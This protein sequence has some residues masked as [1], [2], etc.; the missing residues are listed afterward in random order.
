M[1]RG[2]ASAE[3]TQARLD[4]S[5]FAPGAPLGRTRLAVSRAGFG[6]Y[7]VSAGVNEHA[8]ALE[9]ALASGITLVDTSANY[10]DGGSEELVGRVIAHLVDSGKLRREA[11]V[12]VSKAGYL[13]GQNH[14]LSQERKRRGNPFPELVLYGE[15]LE[16]C[17]H[18]EFLQDQLTRSLERLKL[19][20]LDVFLL[21]NPEYYLGWALKNGLPAGEAQAEY[22]R[23]IENAF[24]HL[25]AEV[26]EGRIR[27]YGISSNTFPAAL[28]DPQFTCL[29]RVWEIAE[30]ISKEHR[31]GVV[32]LPMNLFETG[33]LLT[34]NQPS[35]ATVLEFARQKNLG[36]LINRPLNAITGGRMVR[37]SEVTEAG[38]VPPEEIEQR[39]AAL[40]ETEQTFVSRILPEL[41]LEPGLASRIRTQFLAADALRQVWRSLSGY[42]HWREVRDGYLLP[43]IRGVLEFLDTQ[44]AGARELSAW[45]DAYAGALDAVLQSLGRFYAREAAERIA[46]IKAALAAA[47]PDWAGEATLSRLAVRALGSTAGVSCVLVGMRRTE[48]VDDILAELRMAVVQK[49]R[50]DSWRRLDAQTGP[51]PGMGPPD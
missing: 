36:V 33:A 11:V 43:R 26:A 34:P 5:G 21:H 31:F 40:A 25:E 6:C 39:A 15:G 51:P 12:V 3:A 47:D 14:A 24:R 28:S 41:H 37:L 10:A 32:Q 20:T 17:I 44:A 50:R 23:R 1:I 46:R 49:D 7:R 8:W 30:S 13:Q 42:D 18:P 29:E 19:E 16:H 9:H 45:Q 35:G 38:D 27:W 2:S 22:Y 4:R 48:Y